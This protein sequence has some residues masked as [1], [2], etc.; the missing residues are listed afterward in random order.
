MKKILIMNMSAIAVSIISAVFS[1]NAI[2]NTTKIES[3]TTAMPTSST[4][5]KNATILKSESE[6][7]ALE[8]KKEE[9]KYQVSKS[10]LYNQLA[11]DFN[12][13]G[14]KTVWGLSFDPSFTPKKYDSIEE[15]MLGASNRLNQVWNGNYDD[16]NKVLALKCPI[17]KE[18][19]FVFSN[20]AA[21]VV[22][23]NGVSCDLITPLSNN[24]EGSN[25]EIQANPNSAAGNNYYETGNVLSGPMIVS[26]QNQ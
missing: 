13:K 16:G 20:Y 7:V 22:D 3:P 8:N 5:V 19:H 26:G 25:S 17:K 6:S 12:K 23:A 24:Q 18:I 10:T 11:Y 15:E 1:I 2:A 9:P 14:Y 21:A 4:V